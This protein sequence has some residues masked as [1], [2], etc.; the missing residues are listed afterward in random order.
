MLKILQP[1]VD[2]DSPTNAHRRKRPSIDNN[3][4]EKEG[5]QKSLSRDDYGN[6]M[7]STNNTQ[8]NNE[9]KSINRNKNEKSPKP[10]DKTRSQA[11]SKLSHQKDLSPRQKMS[12][13]QSDHML[14][15]QEERQ[16]LPPQ[17]MS[18][19]F[20]TKTGTKSV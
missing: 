3:S 18:L 10:T 14:I 11:V 12:H 17:Q 19:N 8:L 16:E 9:I 20:E 15:E 5:G 7:T 13:H 4:Y 1:R 2:C 6:E